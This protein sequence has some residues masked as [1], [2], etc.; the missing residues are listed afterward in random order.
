MVSRISLGKNGKDEI[1]IKQPYM[2]KNK[3]QPDKVC[4]LC[5]TPYGLKQSNYLWN[6]KLDK[7]F[8]EFG[9]KQGKFDNY[10]YITV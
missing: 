6:N 4:R 2:F 10:I 9:F 8:K 5:T 7:Y 3:N 1:Y